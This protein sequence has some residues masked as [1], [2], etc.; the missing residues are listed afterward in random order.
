MN[1]SAEQLS[2]RRDEKMGSGG[3]GGWTKEEVLYV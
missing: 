2:E 3:K 1:W